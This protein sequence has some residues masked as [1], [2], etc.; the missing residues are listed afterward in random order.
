MSALDAH[1][2]K[3]MFENCIMETLKRQGKTIFLVTNQLQVR[4]E[5][6]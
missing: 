4:H 6:Q 5:R 1:V 3:E 2:G